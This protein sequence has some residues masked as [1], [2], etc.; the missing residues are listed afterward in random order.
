MIDDY[1]RRVVKCLSLGTLTGSSRLAAALCLPSFHPE[2][3]LRVVEG[4]D[5]TSFRLATLTSSL[6]YS[7]AGQTPRRLEETVSVSSERASRFWD[8]VAGLSPQTIADDPQHGLDGMSVRCIWRQGSVDSTFETW[9]PAPESRH[10]AFIRQIYDLGWEVLGGRVSIE[11]LEQLHV[12]LH[13]GLPVRMIEGPMKCLRIFGSLSSSEEMALRSM[14]STLPKD[15]PLIVDMTNFDGM[16][17]LLYPAFVEFASS[18]RFLS[19]AV[20]PSARRHVESMGLANLRI[21]DTTEDARQWVAGASGGH[22][23]GTTS[24]D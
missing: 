3:L 10:G 24:R 17:T 19:W 1:R 20:S 11:R 23:P 5:G 14:L 18:R 12:Y 7:E 15:E 21:F 2:T 13:L 9:S 6:W 22:D 16:G 4:P 8:S